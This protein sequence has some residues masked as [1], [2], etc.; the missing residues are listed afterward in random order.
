ML[1]NLVRERNCHPELVSGST[2]YFAKV[3]GDT[4]LW[5]NYSIV[6]NNLTGAENQQGS[7]DPSWIVGFSDGE[8][9][10]SVSFVR[11]K[12]VK[13]GYQIFAEFVLTQGAKSLSVL[14]EIQEF[15]QVG[16]IYEN[17]RTDNHRE[18]LYRYCVR[19]ISELDTVIVPFFRKFPLKTA[20]SQD[21]EIFAKVVEMMKNREHL[22]TEGFEEIR[23]LAAQMNR[24]K[25]RVLNPSETNSQTLES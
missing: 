6:S 1:K 4:K 8:G 18:N 2:T 10:F 5:Y 19:S 15:F 7:L 14:E 3:S 12:T 22:T 21:F 20:K 13:F 9:C 17:R 25:L 16:K 11:N 24:R 23:N